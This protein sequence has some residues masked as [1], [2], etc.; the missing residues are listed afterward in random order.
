MADSQSFQGKIIELL[1]TGYNH[2]G[3]GA[4][5]YEGRPVFVDG[6]LKGETVKVDLVQ[7]KKGIITGRLLEIIEAVPERVSPVC[8]VFYSCGGCQLQHL[9]YRAQLLMKQEIVANALQRLGGFE[10]IPVNPVLGTTEPWGYRNKGHFRVSKYGNKINL[11]FYEEGSHKQVQVS[12]EHLFT[13]NVADL[14]EGLPELLEQYN[15]PVASA[16]LP[17][18]KHL[19]I[20][21]SRS[22]NEILLVFVLSRHIEYDFSTI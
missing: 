12:C 19:M 22:R 7:E 14:L 15:T 18:L 5:R 20:R 8:P 13:R 4:G 3:K 17:G 21:E 11:G 1:I 16:E 10:N 6:A 2:E 9:N